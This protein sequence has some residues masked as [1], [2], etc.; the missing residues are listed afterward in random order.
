M[1][2]REYR[3]VEGYVHK[4]RLEAR[5]EVLARGLELPV[6]AVSLGALL[7]KLG[8]VAVALVA[9]GVAGARALI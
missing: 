5:E 6:E 9:I 8:L 7:G 2:A 4:F 1:S 3:A